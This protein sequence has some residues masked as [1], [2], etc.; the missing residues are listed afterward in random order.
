MRAVVLAFASA[1]VL[2]AC[3][4]GG[5][6]ATSNNGAASSAAPA[7]ADGGLFPD[8]SGTSY[9]IEGVAS[10]ENGTT[11][12]VVMVRDGAKLRMEM[13]VSGGSTTIIAN[14]ATGESLV[15]VNVGGRQM[16][17]RGQASTQSFDDPMNDWQGE[18]A[19]RAT[20]TG[21]CNGAGESGDLW[22]QTEE[23][24]VKTVC[25]TR[26]GVMLHATDAGRTVWE[27]RNVQR[28]PQPA[29]AFELPAGV[30]VMDLGN[31]DGMMDA[32]GKAGRR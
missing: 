22:T 21:S 16:A 29:S 32:I 18:L 4:P 20:R 8:L 1:A 19:E 26:D 9:R 28:G 12:P 6:G 2:A 27:T 10:Q 15:I 3:G 5:G 31:M 11:F 23:G 24:A 17:M 30:Q 14:G 7:A 13:N 25:V